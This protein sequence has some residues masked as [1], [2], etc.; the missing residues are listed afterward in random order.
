M[1]LDEFEI[2]CVV[3]DETGII[4]HCGV[5]GYGIQNVELIEKLDLLRN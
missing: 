1:V 3:K 5:K 4:S 2:T